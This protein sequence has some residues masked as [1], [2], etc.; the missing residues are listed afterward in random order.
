LTDW[1]GSVKLPV[2]SDFYSNKIYTGENTLKICVVGAGG[3]G[4]YFGSLLAKQNEVSFVARGEHL[5]AI[6]QNGLRVRY[7][8]SDNSYTEENCRVLTTANPADIGEVDLVFF[9]V[10]V[11]DVKAAAEEIKPLI[12]ATTKVITFQN[13]IDAPYQLAEVIGAEKVV[14]GAARIEATIGEPGLVIRYNVDQFPA[15]LEVAELQG[16]PSPQLEAFLA[17]CQAAEIPAKLEQ[18][19]KQVLWNKFLFLAVMSS[20]SSITRANAGEIMHH[21]PTKAL[22]A[23]LITELAELGRAEG[24]NFPEAM[25]EVAKSPQF[26]PHLTLKSSMQ[27]D[28][29]RGKFPTELDLLAGRA[30]ELGKQYGIAI[31]HLETIYAVL[32]LAE[33]VGYRY[34]DES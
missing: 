18:N 27:R 8:K 31:P 10:K 7:V 4:G 23:N 11:M 14:V 32:S 22:Y 34:S 25:L 26:P 13:G 1:P 28:F 19:P 29:E 2:N 5:A 6:K 21:A 3:V 33:K 16:A 9:A 17:A 30:I 15:N 20:I 24:A 12:G